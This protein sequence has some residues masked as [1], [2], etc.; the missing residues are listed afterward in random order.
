MDIYHLGERKGIVATILN[1]TA[2]CLIGH[3]T[4][5]EGEIQSWVV[6][7]Q[8]MNSPSQNPGYVLACSAIKPPLMLDCM[9]YTRLKLI[10]Q[11]LLNIDKP[12][13]ADK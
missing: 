3:D 8:V 1:Q 7:L 9:K 13:F 12:L 6:K 2:T 11:C 10:Q 5:R 4:H